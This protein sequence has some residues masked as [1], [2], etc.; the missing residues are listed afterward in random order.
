MVRNNEYLPLNTNVFGNLGVSTV[1]IKTSFS[2]SSGQFNPTFETFRENRLI[3]AD[4]LASQNQPIT[5]RDETGFP[6]GYG[7]S[8]QDVVLHSFLAAYLGAD[9][10]KVALEPIKRIGLP[11]WNLKYS[12]L[13]KIPS[14]SKIFSRFSLNHGYRASYTI[15]N[16]QTNFDYDADFPL[17]TDV[18]GNIIPERLFSNVTLVEQ[19]NPLMQLD[20]EL[21]NNFK[22]L[23]E[24]NRD[25]SLSLSLDNNLLTEV[26]G[27]E[28]VGGLGY[29]FRDLRMRTNFNGRRIILKG[30]LNIKADLS[31]RNN[32]TVIRN[33]E[34]DNNQVT[35]GQKTFIL[36]ITADYALSRNVMATFFYDHNFSKF[37]ISTAFPQTSIRSGFTLRYNFGN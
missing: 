3:V 17:N 33:L 28:Y 34:Y 35:A 24:I 20:M 13:N 25:R 4:R 37:A 2:Q 11:N 29:R 21:K 8:Q 26:S 23:I 14:L 1:M 16:F 31:Y 10:N 19:F 27:N 36:K 32:I 15:N 5:E 30:D 6:K 22:F 7:K 9:P 18:T 12:G